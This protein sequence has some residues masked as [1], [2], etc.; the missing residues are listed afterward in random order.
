MLRSFFIAIVFLAMI[1]CGEGPSPV[2]S[3]ADSTVLEVEGR[4]LSARRLAPV[5]ES[6]SGDSAS[7]ENAVRNLVNRYL[8]LA[9]AH[10]RGLDETREFQLYAYEREREKLQTLWLEHILAQKVVIPP[11]SVEEHYSKLGTMLIYSA[12]S[13]WERDSAD[14]LRQ[15]VLE[16][17]DMN[18]LAEEHSINPMERARQGRVG[19]V[20]SMEVR[21]DDTRML[22]GMEPGDVSRVFALADTWRFLRLDSIYQDSV[23]PLPEVR[24]YIE[25]RIAG[26]LRMAYKDVLL[27]SLRQEYRLEIDEPAVEL[28]AS[29]F[30]PGSM[31]YDPFTPEE[32]ETSVYSY[33]GGGRTVYQ[34][35]ENISRLPPV[36]GT[37]PSDPSWVKGYCRLLGVYDIMGARALEAGMDTLPEVT[38]YLDDRLSDHLLDIYYAEVIQ[39]RLT[40]GDNEMMEVYEEHRDSLVVPETRVFRVISAAGEDQLDLLASTLEEGGNP[41]RLTDDLTLVESLLAPGESS[42]TRGMYA[43]EIPRPY[44]DMLFDAELNETVICSIAVDR[45]LVFQPVDIQPPR[46]ATFEESYDEIASMLRADKEEE[47]V[48][49]LVDSLSSVYHIEIDR[50]FVESYIHAAPPSQDVP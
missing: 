2:A 7:V 42:L 30:I 22:E 41:F 14:S 47:V 3:P 34:L 49:G 44:S 36:E 37:N 21:A 31:E 39:P 18:L 25:A 27:D 8:I 20:D 48:S 46:P 26:R 11:D 10:S 40:P 9:D 24:D 1:G 45:V 17:E 32:E 12:V 35:A 28:V 19:P 6:E 16:G 38:D 5:L 29:H 4:T 15:L 23:P 13:V 43:S 50:D 33:E